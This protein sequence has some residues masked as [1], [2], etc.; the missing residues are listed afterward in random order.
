MI[1]RSYEA[2]DI[3][4][5]HFK[6]LQKLR[7]TIPYILSLQGNSS[8]RLIIL[9]F[10]FTNQIQTA[11]AMTPTECISAGGV[12]DKNRE[13]FCGEEKIPSTAW[14]C[15]DGTLV[16][17]S[18]DQISIK[19][20]LTTIEIGQNAA[21][22]NSHYSCEMP[23]K[24]EAKLNLTE[25][26]HF[27]S[28]ARTLN[29]NGEP[30]GISYLLGD[31]EFCSRISLMTEEDWKFL[32]NTDEETKKTLLLVEKQISN[33]KN[34]IIDLLNQKSKIKDQNVGNSK[35]QDLNRKLKVAIRAYDS[36]SKAAVN[37]TDLFGVISAIRLR[38]AYDNSIKT[39][40]P[41]TSG[42]VSDFNKTL[43]S[44]TATMKQF[45]EAKL[46]KSQALE[47]RESANQ[48]E[49]DM[50][51]KIFMTFLEAS[52]HY[53]NSRPELLL[54]FFTIR[55]SSESRISGIKS[56]QSRTKSKEERK[57]I[58]KSVT[59]DDNFLVN[60]YQSE[61]DMNGIYSDVKLDSSKRLR[62]PPSDE[63]DSGRKKSESSRSSSFQLDNTLTEEKTRSSNLN[64]DDSS[65][66]NRLIELG[67]QYD[68]AGS[69]E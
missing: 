38:H 60:Q 7:P 16:P 36:L 25:L 23:T 56:K 59:F 11:E 13:C 30:V 62:T 21:K 24:S 53:S 6:F 27:V 51:E 44:A 42:M 43:Q 4:M 33:R 19:N 47:F 22:L 55:Q 41:M 1:S 58:N 2:Y 5:W 8:I 57:G 32:L 31:P 3:Y 66:I 29:E 48:E 14:K 34:E 49:S 45:E 63:G 9:L 64:P 15:T 20:L 37:A 54:S 35:L 61:P 18:S 17:I 12:W 28:I 26:G 69:Q 39:N 68:S 46:L 65:I 50:S 40:T 10:L 67:R 52:N